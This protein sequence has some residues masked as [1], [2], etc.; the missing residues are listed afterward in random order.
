VERNLA[1][2]FSWR[3]DGG[4]VD[5]NAAFA[6][7]L[8][9]ESREQVIGRS[10]HD[11]QIDPR[12]QEPLC[13]VIHEEPVSNR[14]VS[15]RR[16]DGSTVHLLMNI[17]PV[18][19][20][21]GTLYETTAIDVTQLRQNQA[22]LQR[23][24]D[25][26]VFESLNDPLTGLPNRKLLMDTLSSLLAVAEHDAGMIAL[27]YLDLDG[28]KVVN[29]SLGHAVGDGMLVQVARRLRSWMREG[30]ML[31]RLGGDEFMVV[32]HAIRA[33]EDAVMLAENLLEE[34]SSSF[35]VNEHT[36]SIGASIGIS[37]YPDDGAGAEELIQR[38]DSAMYVGKREGKNRVT[39][40]TQEI[41][42]QV[43]ERLTLEH[44]LRGAIARKELFLNYQPEFELAGLRLTR[45]EALARWTHPTLG[46]ISPAKFIPIAEESGM[47]SALGS[48]LMEQ[49]CYEAVNWQKM[50]PHPIQV[51]VN[52]STV[53]FRRKGFVEEVIAIL[54]RTGLRPELL[55][56]EVTESVMLAGL[57]QAAETIGRL[58][59]MGISLAIDDFGT[60]YSSLSYLPSLAFDVLKIDRSFVINLTSEPETASMIR[61][62]ITLA[63]NFGMQVIVEG[64]ESSEQLAIIKA[65][66][67]NEVQGYLTGRPTSNPMKYIL[68]TA[69][70]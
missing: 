51:A 68:R 34:I 44:Q 6:R 14:R 39:C 58:R 65:L 26:A 11:F 50:T 66:G 64:V 27:L 3:P 1:A 60:G 43:H 10:C 8:G 30:D 49:A 18:H 32:M 17:T 36:L 9:F 61:T 67:A 46:R 42:T 62:L 35:E 45:F 40:F 25:V 12:Q 23:A 22:E 4:V 53:Q 5:C 19:T 47:I 48:Y 2:V 29:D 69:S 63:H 31:A 37:I 20:A 21:E 59:D 52:I 41:G 15:L 16:D 70:L 13:G 56:I 38:A 24:K 55:Q 7:M 54:D 57:H 33:R 28:F